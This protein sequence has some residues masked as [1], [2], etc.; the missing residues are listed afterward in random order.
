MRTLSSQKLLKKII[1]R[2]KMLERENFLGD[3]L[4]QLLSYDVLFG[5]GVRGKFKGTMKRNYTSLTESLEYYMQKYKCDKRED[6]IKVFE[7]LDDTV[8]IKKPK[9]IYLNTLMI[10]NKK[11]ISNKLK[12]DGFNRIKFENNDN[13]NLNLKNITNKEFIKDE[14]IKKMLIFSADSLL[15]KNYSLFKEGH[16]LQID[17]VIFN[18]KISLIYHSNSIHIVKLFSTFGIESTN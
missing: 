14:H 16:L 15:N 2:S 12:S 6:L 18:F 10:E 7:S 13:L 8:R 3:K 11:E 4:A 17:K 1:K 5:Q 9:Y